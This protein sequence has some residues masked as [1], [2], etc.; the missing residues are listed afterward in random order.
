MFQ[1][2]MRIRRSPTSLA[3]QRDFLEKH[4]ICQQIVSIL[5][6]NSKMEGD[7]SFKGVVAAPLFWVQGGE[8]EG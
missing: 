7:R 1:R 4:Q 8:A 5:I 6:K 2:A 3:M